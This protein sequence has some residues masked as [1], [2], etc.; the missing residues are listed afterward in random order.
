VVRRWR[1][2]AVQIAPLEERWYRERMLN[3]QQRLAAHHQRSEIA[4]RVR[5]Q[6]TAIQRAGQ[7]QPKRTLRQ[8]TLSPPAC[9]DEQPGLRPGLMDVEPSHAMATAMVRPQDWRRN[10]QVGLLDG[11]RLRVLRS[12]P[13]ALIAAGPK[14]CGPNDVTLKQDAGMSGGKV[15]EFSLDAVNDAEKDLPELEIDRGA[16]AESHRAGAGLRHLEARLSYL[17]LLDAKGRVTGTPRTEGCH[18]ATAAEGPKDDGWGEDLKSEEGYRG[19]C[20]AAQRRNASRRGTPDIH[21]RAM[22]AAERSDG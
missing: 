21:S 17:Q 6:R 2:R 15:E 22:C 13:Q 18:D 10:S 5:A 19:E 16:A 14:G 7:A 12:G 4:R 9:F 8:G 1:S 20:A 3:Q 11:V